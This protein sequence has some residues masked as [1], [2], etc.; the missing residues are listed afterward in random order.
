MLSAVS[1]FLSVFQLINASPAIF[2]VYDDLLAF[3]KYE[4]VIS[5]T[6][7]SNTEA[8]A[9]L[10]QA[11]PLTLPQSSKPSES[12][13][14]FSDQTD[15]PISSNSDSHVSYELIYFHQEPYLCK[16]PLLETPLRNETLEQETRTAERQELARA[17]V[18]GWELLQELEDECLYFI[19]GWWS[20]SF[21]H[22]S[23]VTQ[24]HQLA[25]QP[26]IRGP[27][28]R[29]PSTKQFVL[30][31]ATTQNN[32]RAISWK[33][34]N[35][36][37]EM[38]T[39]NSAPRMELQAKGGTRYLVQRLEGGTICDLTGK[40]R[41]IEVQFHCSPT[42]TDRIGYI[43]EVVTCSYLMAIYTPRLCDDVAFLPPKENKAHTITC[44]TV[45]PDKDLAKMVELQATGT[46]LGAESPEAETVEPPKIVGGI[47]LG[48]GKW[49]NVDSERM[50]I[51]DDFSDEFSQQDDAIVEIIARA[52]SKTE[53]GQVEV[54]TEADL[55]KLDLDPEMIETLRKEVQKLANE[56]GWK[57]EIIDAPG[58][59]RKILGIVDG[60]DDDEEGTGEKNE[61]VSTKDEL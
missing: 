30:G 33:K 42:A 29:D 58:Q 1:I 22:N 19:S 38:N 16:I 26:G 8:S 13:T 11:S 21:C 34:G 52:K 59:T 46:Q 48:A 10:S 60:N 43:K 39:R 4:I 44:H 40:P 5:E 6:Y 41:K 14:S 32:D 20:Y 51:P 57:I 54:A 56:K 53:G 18:R 2:S 55:K 36:N 7:I 61:D 47:V 31:R 24:F 15:E 45:L 49:I 9:L 50:P 23:E 37:A 3:P 28:K 12:T 27:P 17:T 35:R 25:P